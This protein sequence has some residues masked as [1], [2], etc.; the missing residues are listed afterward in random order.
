MTQEKP[1]TLLG[2][3]TTMVNRDSHNKGYMRNQATNKPTDAR[4]DKTTG[5]FSTH[6]LH[7]EHYM[8]HHPSEYTETK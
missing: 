8:I 1:T 5:N 3:C 7:P 6:H 4:K 2:R